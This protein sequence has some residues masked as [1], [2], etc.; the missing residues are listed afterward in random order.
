MIL[1][2]WEARVPEEGT[3]FNPA[4]CGALI[5]EFV[6]Q[7]TTAKGEACP[8]AL[9][10]CALAISLHAKI[11]AALPG[12][13]VTSLYTWRERNSEALIGYADRA[14]SLRPTLQ[15]AIRF[16][17][18]RDTLAISPDGGLQLG[19]VRVPFTTKFESGLTHDA[20][21]CVSCTRLLGRWFARA[22]TASTILAGWGIKP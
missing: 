9:P 4:F 5:V 13:T 14:R 20:R 21:D 3:L 17:I 1:A 11:R 15:E 12:S 6:K 7:Y 19:T 18:E 2:R 16:C 10:F 22:G 8:F